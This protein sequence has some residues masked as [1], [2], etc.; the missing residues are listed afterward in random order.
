LIIGISGITYIHTTIG[1][2]LHEMSSS[3]DFH[4]LSLKNALGLGGIII[5]VLIPVIIR[6]VW[7]PPSL[8]D[9]TTTSAT[10]VT[11]Y[12]DS[13]NPSRSPFVDSPRAPYL[14]SPYIDNTSSSEQLAAPDFA[15]ELNAKKGSVPALNLNGAGMRRYSDREPLV[16]ADSDDDTEE[17][18]R[19]RGTGDLS[20]AERLLG[21]QIN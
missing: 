13:P 12:A 8:D 17:V 19:V 2:T 3:K 16:E 11:P 6:R 4:L 20:K 14:D 7:A 10:P 18:E 21:T 5:A 15:A 9:D 1:T